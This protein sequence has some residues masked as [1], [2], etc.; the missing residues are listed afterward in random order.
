MATGELKRNREF[1]HA[2]PEYDMS[3]GDTEWVLPMTNTY[4]W[5][6]YF[7]IENLAGTGDGTLAVK[8]SGDGGTTW[9]DYPNMST[10]TVDSDKSISFD[11][12][13]TVYDKIKVVF[14]ANS[15]TGG[16]IT[17]NQRLYTNPIK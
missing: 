17:L 6:Y 3:N 15:I 13:Y 16:T 1:V 11:D 4:K 14:T 9:V 2:I 10:E 8:C 7:Q 12:S 5:M